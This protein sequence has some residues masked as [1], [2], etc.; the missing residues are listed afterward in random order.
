MLIGYYAVILDQHRAGQSADR[1]A[2][3]QLRVIR[4]FL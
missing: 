4:C 1:Q 3:C 2:C